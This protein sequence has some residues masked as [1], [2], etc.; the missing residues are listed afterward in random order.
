[1]QERLITQVSI[2][3]KEDKITI[4]FTQGDRDYSVVCLEQAAPKFYYSIQSFLG[5]FIESAGLDSEY[6]NKG[7]VKKIVLEH[8][9]DLT[10]ISFS[11][12]ASVNEKYATVPSPS[13]TVE[14][15][16]QKLVDE[17]IRQAI[18]Y[19]DGDRSQQSLL[20]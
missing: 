1:M 7:F 5:I 6:W 4:K 20:T 17:L 14:E 11:G 2:S 9:E 16:G 18:A 15:A 10:L 12:T 13:R 8:Y 19:L 3:G